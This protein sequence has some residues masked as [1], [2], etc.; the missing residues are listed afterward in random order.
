M[1]VVTGSY[2][3]HRNRTVSYQLT[4]VGRGW[5]MGEY[6]YVGCDSG[7]VYVLQGARVYSAVCTRYSLIV[8]SHKP[9]VL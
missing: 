3:I 6:V 5:G 1:P 2:Q 9:V 4:A 7:A 8:S